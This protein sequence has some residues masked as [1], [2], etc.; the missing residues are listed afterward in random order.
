MVFYQILSF[1][2]LS[3]VI[4]LTI[5]F[6]IYRY[7]INNIHEKF[8]KFLDKL[9]TNIN[10][11]KIKEKLITSKR[12]IGSSSWKIENILALLEENTNTFIKK[13]KEKLQLMDLILDNMPYGVLIIN[14]ER[15]IIKINDSLSSL[16]YLDKKKI[17]G[18][19]TIL[20]FN[21]EKFEN[22]ISRVLTKLSPQGEAIVFYQDGEELYLDVEAI[23][24]TSEGSPIKKEDMQAIKNEEIELNL[25]IL[26]RN[27]TQEAEFS[28]LRSQF[29]ANVSHEMR[30]PL[31]SIKGYIE[32]SLED[33][34]ENRER[35]KS[36]LNKSLKEVNRLN[37]LIEDVLNLS[38]IEFKRNILFKK[39][40]NIIDIINDCIESLHF[41]AEQ[42]NIE[43]GF[44]YKACSTNYN[45]D[46]ELFRQAVY[47]IIENSIFYA[48][49]GA[50][51]KIGINEDKNNI[52]ISFTDN[53][54]G[55]SKK[56]LPYIFQRFYRGSNPFS[57][58]HIGS[59]L[60]LSI[61]KHIIELHNGKITASSKPDIET[62]FIIKLPKKAA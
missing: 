3:I 33:N 19:K 39:K 23:P 55:I 2:F 38:K 57:L 61:V 25:V 37:Y 29:V 50:K 52:I 32:T 36:Y 34:L 27:I 62:R 41:L 59:G 30:T 28:K 15:R 42:N 14:K 48:G 43:I 54:I 18:S 11:T 45:A 47:N 20:A 26:L 46:E 49:E 12:T 17:L 53:G 51:L 22:L 60:G 21:N 31:T 16:F 56:D 58:K 5:L 4:L 13:C 7:R 9:K 1:I 40:C 24:V 44:N 8:Q 6:L 10:N 35:V